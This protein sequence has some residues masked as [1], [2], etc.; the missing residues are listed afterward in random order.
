MFVVSIVSILLIRRYDGARAS[1][2]DVI[3]YR[4]K[5]NYGTKQGLTSIR[6]R[7]QQEGGFVVGLS[8]CH[9]VVK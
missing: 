8:G 9:R 2:F 7:V 6:R 5:G 3:V 1:S 4:F